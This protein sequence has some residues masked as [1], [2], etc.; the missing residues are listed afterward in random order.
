[1]NDRTRIVIDTLMYIWNTNWDEFCLTV[2]G[3]EYN[4]AEDHRKEWVSKYL[5]AYQNNS[6]NLFALLD[7]NN[8]DKITEAAKE[9]YGEINGV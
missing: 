3:F 5:N 2:F 4:T 7:S 6:A 8:M 9:R 1:M